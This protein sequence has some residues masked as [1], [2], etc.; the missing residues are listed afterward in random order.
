MV[1]PFSGCKLLKDDRCVTD[2]RLGSRMGRVKWAGS[3]L[4]CYVVKI[5][6]EPLH[7]PKCLQIA[8]K[9]WYAK[10]VLAKWAFR[11][12]YRLSLLVSRLPLFL[13]LNLILCITQML[14]QVDKST[15]K[16][17]NNLKGCKAVGHE[18]ASHQGAAGGGGGGDL[19][20]LRVCE[21]TRGTQPCSSLLLWLWR[22]G[23]CLWQVR[24]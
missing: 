7:H 14:S 11:G 6:L 17:F 1:W 16:C 22:P 3:A 8:G 2:V 23:W 19:V 13:S 15:N 21:Q 18:E 9:L 5:C 24:H 4:Q 12:I 10:E 20:L